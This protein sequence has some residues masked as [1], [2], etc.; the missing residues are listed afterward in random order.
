M[1]FIDNIFVWLN[2]STDRI[3]LLNSISYT[4]LITRY[5]IEET[6][7]V[8]QNKKKLFDVVCKGRKTQVCLEEN[9]LLVA[10]FYMFSTIPQLLL[11]SKDK[12]RQA[13][14]TNL[15]KH[16][17][18][19]I[20]IWYIL[21]SS[22]SHCNRYNMEK[23]KLS[24]N[25]HHYCHYHSNNF[26]NQHFFIDT[27]KKKKQLEKSKISVVYEGFKKAK[28]FENLTRKTKKT[29]IIVQTQVHKFIV[30]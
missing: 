16:K 12:T 29:R 13:A 21:I 3:E 24:N 9:N 28:Y 6:N 11:N 30:T 10:V 20:N 5:F 19:I 2:N 17:M 7:F 25:N 8:K 26:I 27:S 23:L 18:D 1:W 15:I 22:N 4:C 14:T